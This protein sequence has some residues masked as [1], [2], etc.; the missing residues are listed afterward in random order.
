MA[1]IVCSLHNLQL[2][3]VVDFVSTLQLLHKK[4]AYNLNG[5]FNDQVL[6]CAAQLNV[7]ALSHSCVFF[8]IHG[9]KDVMR[10]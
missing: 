5:H 1:F 7:S 6:E 4:L 2:S 8:V 10:V 9:R 3:N